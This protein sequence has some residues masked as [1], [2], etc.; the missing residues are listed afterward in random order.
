M[1]GHQVWMGSNLCK[2][3]Q[4]CLNLLAFTPPKLAL[5]TQGP[6]L[7][8]RSSLLL[9]FA[10]VKSRVPLDYKL[11]TRTQTANVGLNRLKTDLML[12]VSCDL[13]RAD[14]ITES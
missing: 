1:Q 9:G 13:I 12:L 2:V 3:T 7:S 14:D 4:M 8:P 5:T 11:E 6:D 10:C